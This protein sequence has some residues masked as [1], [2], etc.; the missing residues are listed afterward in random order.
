MVYDI[1]GIKHRN[2]IEEVVAR[3]GVALRQS[4][5]GR[6]SWVGLA[7]TPLNTLA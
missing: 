7:S 3:H 1:D 4:R 6:M 2:P 5:K